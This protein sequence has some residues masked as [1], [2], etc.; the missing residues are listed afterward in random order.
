[1]LRVEGLKAHD[2]APLT[3]D[4]SMN[5]QPL[6]STEIDALM[7][8]RGEWTLNPERTAISRQFRFGS[9]IEAMGFMTEAAI[10]AEKIDHHP[11]WSNVYG[12]VSVVLTTHSA[13]GLTSLDF[14]L[15]AFMDKIAA[16]R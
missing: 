10:M 2:A 3:G 4:E 12:R 1:M 11:E 9:F 15:A 8:E 6:Q 13:K 5:R 16:R 14:N 7:S